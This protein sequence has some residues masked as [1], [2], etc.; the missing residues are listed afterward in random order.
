MQRADGVVK[1]LAALVVAAQLLAQH[2]QNPG[3]GEL[4]PLLLLRR[5]G[6][7]FQCIQQPP[8]IAIGIRHQPLDRFTFDSWKRLL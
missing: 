4:R 3:I 8:R 2:L 7:G 6:Q 1:L 5:H